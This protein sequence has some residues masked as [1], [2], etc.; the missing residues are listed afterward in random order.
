MLVIFWLSAVA[1]LAGPTALPPLTVF[2]DPLVPSLTAPRP[3]EPTRIKAPSL[4]LHTELPDP[5]P[6]VMLLATVDTPPRL[7]ASPRVRR[8]T[9]TCDLVVAVDPHGRV[10]NPRVVSGDAGPLAR[11]AKRRVRR[12]R[13]SPARYAGHPVAV[14]DLMVT[15]PVGR[16]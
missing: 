11:R 6:V 4:P 15:V 14:A 1:A 16:R 13:F 12:F 2:P 8:P 3:P 5:G 7:R 10:S 9:T